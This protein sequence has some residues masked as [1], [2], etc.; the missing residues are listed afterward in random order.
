MDIWNTCE[1][2]H[3]LGQTRNF[4]GM[5]AVNQGHPEKAF[6]ILPPQP[7]HFADLNVRLMAL[8]ECGRFEDIRETLKENMAKPKNGHQI[9]KEA[10]S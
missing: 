10:V 6:E 3:Q 9:S 7:I 4:L 5:L 1:K 2:S 8:A